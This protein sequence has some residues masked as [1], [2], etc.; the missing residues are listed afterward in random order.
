METKIQIF[1][2]RIRQSTLIIGV[3][4]LFWFLY[5]TGT[6]PSRIVY[7]CQRAAASNCYAFLLYPAFAFIVNFVKTEVPRAYNKIS[8]SQKA[9]FFI[10]IIMFSLTIISS[11]LAIYNNVFFDPLSVIETQTGPAQKVSEVSVVQV[12]NN[13]LEQSLQEALNY[14]GGISSIIPEGAKVL[15]KPNIVRYQS[16]PDTTDPA[17]VKALINL[18]KQRNPSVIWVAEGSGEG[19]TIENFMALGYS[20]IAAMSGVELVDLNYGDLVE[21]SIPGGGYVFDSFMFNK[22]VV[23][24]DVFISL[25]CMKTHSMAVVTLGM[26]N[27]V[28]ISAGSVYGVAN[29]ANHWRLHE[30]AAEKGDTYLGGVITDLNSARRIDL[31]IIDGRVAME[32]QGPHDGEP[33]NLGLIIVGKDPVATDTV[34]STIMGFDARKIPTLALAAQKGLGTN[35]LDEIEVKG[36][37]VK[38]VFHPFAPAK[39][40]NSFLLISDVQLLMYRWRE[41]LFLPAIAF[42]SLTVLV[43]VLARRT[44]KHTVQGLRMNNVTRQEMVIDSKPELTKK[45]ETVVLFSEIS[46]KHLEEEIKDKTSKF[47]HHLRQIE[48]TLIRLEEASKLLNSREISHNIYEVLTADLAKQLIS[49]VETLVNMREDLELI[50]SR[51][52]IEKSKNIE[53]KDMTS[54]IS[55]SPSTQEIEDL[56]YVRGYKDIVESQLWSSAGQPVYSSTFD[57]WTALISQIDS[58]LSSLPI[59]KEL[60]IIEKFL[61]LTKDNATYETDSERAEKTIFSC[62]QRLKALSEKW[63][64]IRRTKIEQ[65]ANLENEAEIIKDQIKELETRFFVGEI[66]QQIFEYENNKLQSKIKNVENQ[67]SEIKSSLNEMDTV[68]F[69]SAD[70]L[71]EVF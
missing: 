46:S 9:P 58:A 8:H 17:I 62:K 6:K 18:I 33:V 59:D 47:K 68:I 16:P 3:F 32:G 48:E 20:E 5:R 21:V 39:G 40:H 31:T 12:E 57:K 28:G 26:K 70:L 42:G 65:L 1:L 13:H 4:S 23:E 7:P 50:R 61:L 41:L 25:A 11:G 66:S 45:D 49:S 19:N 14:I 60:K 2:R 54:T 30:V 67:I 10:L 51:A 52:M 34:A 35:K 71:K 63:D 64:S 56:R 69:R 22:K 29:S 15:I 37:T 27:L 44:Q 55:N 36:K 53:T 24:A 43:F 38:E